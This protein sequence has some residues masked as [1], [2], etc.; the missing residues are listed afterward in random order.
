MILNATS[1]T[2]AAQVNAAIAGQ[3]VC[4]AT[5]DYGTWTGT[6][7]AITIKAADGATPQMKVNFDAGDSSFTLD[8]MTEMGG[9]INGSSNITIKNSK[10]SRASCYSTGCLRIEGATSNVIIDNNDFSFPNWRYLRW[11]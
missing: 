9:F 6:N 7:K 10:F 2:F 11:C 3:T 5:G 4:L 1:A 8:G